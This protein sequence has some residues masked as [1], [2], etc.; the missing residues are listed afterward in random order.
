MRFPKRSLTLIGILLEID[1]P[2]M[3][4]NVDPVIVQGSIITLLALMATR[5]IYKQLK[6]EKHL[7]PRNATSFLSFLK[8]RNSFLFSVCREIKP[9]SWNPWNHK[10]SEVLEELIL[11]VNKKQYKQVLDEL[12]GRVS[13][14]TGWEEIY[15]SPSLK[16][17]SD[18]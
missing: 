11:R 10:Y 15:Q 9:E 12:I 4:I 8:L 6:K 3:K 2:Q 16:L 14:R 7:E 18:P 13:Y 17:R 5:L 1:I